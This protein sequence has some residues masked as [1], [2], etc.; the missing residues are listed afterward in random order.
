MV[1]HSIQ[2]EMLWLPSTEVY[3]DKHP[4]LFIVVNSLLAISGVVLLLKA[5]RN[6]G[7]KAKNANKT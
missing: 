2:K 4:M 6:I 3:L 1:Y 5:M 7:S